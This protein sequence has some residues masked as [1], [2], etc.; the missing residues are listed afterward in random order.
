MPV[1]FVYLVFDEDVSAI[2]ACLPLSLLSLRLS[3]GSAAA[4]DRVLCAVPPEWIERVPSI[5]L[6]LWAVPVE[7][8][9]SHDAM[10]DLV[11]SRVPDATVAVFMGP[12]TVVTRD[13]A[14]VAIDLLDDCTFFPGRRVIIPLGPLHPV[15]RPPFLARL[16]GYGVGVGGGALIA[17]SPVSHEAFVAALDKKGTM[18]VGLRSG[19]GMHVGS[20]CANDMA[21]AMLSAEWLSRSND[22]RYDCSLPESAEESLGGRIAFYTVHLSQRRERAAKVAEARVELAR[23]ASVRGLPGMVIRTVEA[24]DG[25]A[26]LGTDARMR[27]L[28]DSGFLSSCSPLPLDEYTG[29]PLRTNNVAAFMSHRRALE[30]VVTDRVEYAVIVEDDVVFRPR[31]YEAV[32]R[33]VRALESEPPRQAAADV[34]QLHVMPTQRMDYMQ[35]WDPDRCGT[36]WRL[37]LS[38]SGTWGMQ[39]YLVTAAAA[40]ALLRPGGLWPM[41]GAVDEQLSRIDTGVVRL[42]ALVGYPTVVDEDTRSAPS[43]TAESIS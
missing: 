18:S 2:E 6:D 32:E 24:V 38:P 37:A 15:M 28:V 13:V 29:V 19:N 33:V 34:V 10:C 11:R 12:R 9:A 43:V 41:R 25:A 22:A 31:F 14:A 30:R 3:V 7:K 39:A 23:Q 36:T 8:M 42:R 4:A 16:C 20:T 40:A 21:L 35:T 17:P 5:D 27:E 1:A 26:E